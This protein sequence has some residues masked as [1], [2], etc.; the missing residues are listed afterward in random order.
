MHSPLAFLGVLLTG[1]V[2][3]LINGVVG[4]GSVVSYPVMLATGLNPIVA[5][6]TNSVGVSSA[7]LFGVLFEFGL[8]PPFR[9][10][11]ERRLESF[12]CLRSQPGS[13]TLQSPYFCCS[14]PVRS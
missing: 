14:P 2:V 13:L 1:L 8:A 4:G 11:A 5:T 3:G 9:Q 10:P 12:Y 6:I 7:N